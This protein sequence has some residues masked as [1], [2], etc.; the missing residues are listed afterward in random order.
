MMRN[1]TM[2]LKGGVLAF[3]CAAIAA[4]AQVRTPGT[5]PDLDNDLPVAQQQ[6][7]SVAIPREIAP[8]M[9]PYL[10]CRQSEQG[11]TLYDADGNMLN[12]DDPTESCDSVREKS[13]NH[14]VRMLGDLNLGR[15]RG[16]RVQYAERWLAKIDELT[17]PDM[18]AVQDQAT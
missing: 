7:D 15:H 18:S 3:A 6:L 12:R 5:L 1:S 13:K 8:A 10:I 14:T 17:G 2:I 11:V 16:E 4:T 9:M